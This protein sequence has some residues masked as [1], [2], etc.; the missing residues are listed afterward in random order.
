VEAIG[1]VAGSGWAAGL[2]LYLVTFLLGL[3]GRLGWAD[4]PDVLSRTDVMA[5][6]AILYLVEFFADKVP[7]LDNLWDALHT[8]VRPL[9]AAALGAVIGGESASIG[10]ALGALIA[11]A[12]ALN[13]HAA[14]ASTRAAVNTS[15]EPFSNITLSV[16]EDGLVAGMM[17]L[18]FA[19]PWVTITLVILLAV[20][21]GYLTSLLWRAL[22]KAWRRARER[23]RGARR[24]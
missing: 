8:V 21:A 6:A 9:G 3:A 17:A 16:F 2:N 1:L 13:S 15:P 4:L 14:K 24:P 11:G 19:N 20:G 5:A 7:Y 18:A 10:A 12:L 23:F 22:G